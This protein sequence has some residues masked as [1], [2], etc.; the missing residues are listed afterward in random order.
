MESGSTF[1]FTIRPVLF[2]RYVRIT[3]LR[4]ADAWLWAMSLSKRLVLDVGVGL[5]LE[6]GAALAEGEIPRAAFPVE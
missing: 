4:T 6:L 2:F 5:V 3:D 1:R